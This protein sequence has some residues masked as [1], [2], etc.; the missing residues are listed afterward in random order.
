MGRIGLGGG[1]SKRIIF[2][3]TY[4]DIISV[5]NLLGAWREFVRGKRKRLDVQE[6][7][8][9][10][11]DNVLE[12]HNDLNL[13]TYRHDGYEAFNISDPKPRSIHKATVRDRLIHR[14]IYRK[15]YPFC[16]RIFTADSYSCRLNK[17]THKALNRFRCF[18]WK[19][20]KN[21]TKTVWVLKCDIR[22]FFANIDHEVLLA[23]LATRIMDKDVLWLLRQVIFS[24]HSTKQGKGLPLG[25]LTSQL[26]VNIYMNV[27]DQFVKHKLKARYYIRYADDFVILSQDKNQLGILLRYIVVFLKETLHLNLH[28]DK[29]SIH[30]IASGVDFLG[31]VHFTDHRILRKA[32]RRRMIKNLREN[33][34]LETRASYLGLLKSGNT[35]TLLKILKLAE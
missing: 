24:F 11:R 19:A 15:I 4:Q 33:H 1:H 3:H 21:H 32:T 30:T 6:F 12:L 16:E 7:G 22:K 17:G 10:L 31:W 25:N 9:R 8:L 27:F 5:E 35:Q 13:K 28:P 2:Q 14:A 23:I 18:A 29:V 26:L 20:S 34:S